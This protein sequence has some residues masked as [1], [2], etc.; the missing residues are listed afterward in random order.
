MF[1]ES[2]AT[3]EPEVDTAINAKLDRQRST[4]EMIASENFA[5]IAVLQAQGSVLTNK[6]AE[7]CDRQMLVVQRHMFPALRVEV[8]S[9]LLPDC[10]LPRGFCP[11]VP[12]SDPLARD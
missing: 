8:G 3:V 9:F 6:Y 2:I 1:D 11:V 4:L 12:R 10:P 7:G 5:P